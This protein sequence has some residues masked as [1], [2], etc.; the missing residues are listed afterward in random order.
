MMLK[1]FVKELLGAY[2][3]MEQFNHGRYAH[4]M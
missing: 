2:I 1:C 3:A 4:M